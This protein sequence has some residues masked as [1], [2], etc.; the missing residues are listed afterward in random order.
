MQFVVEIH[1]SPWL[2]AGQKNCPAQKTYVVH[3]TTVYISSAS[4]LVHQ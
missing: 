4:T 3:E 2:H 1:H